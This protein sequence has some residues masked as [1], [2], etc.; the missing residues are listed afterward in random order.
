MCTGQFVCP[1]VLFLSC[2]RLSP[3]SLLPLPF[4]RTEDKRGS[5][6]FLSTQCYL[7]REGSHHTKHGTSGG[8]HI[9]CVRGAGSSLNAGSVALVE[10]RNSRYTIHMPWNASCLKK[11]NSRNSSGSTNYWKTLANLLKPVDM[12]TNFSVCEIKLTLA[13]SWIQIYIL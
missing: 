2:V 10:R 7:R 13:S 8:S 5:S 1:V 3:S 4:T 9:T 12:R 6:E 11:Q